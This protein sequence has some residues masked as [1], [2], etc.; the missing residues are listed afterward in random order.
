MNKK[1]S[2]ADVPDTKETGETEQVIDRPT[3][4]VTERGPLPVNESALAVM[5]PQHSQLA[6]SL[7]GVPETFLT[8]Y[9]KTIARVYKTWFFKQPHM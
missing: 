9:E 6:M 1:N 4:Q 8:K 7:A 2:K 5:T 3:E